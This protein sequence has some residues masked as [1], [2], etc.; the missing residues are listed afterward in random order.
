M[1][2]DSHCHITCDQLY[3]HLDDVLEGMKDFRRA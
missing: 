1:Y 2:T 3:D